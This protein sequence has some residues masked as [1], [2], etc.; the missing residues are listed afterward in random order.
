[1]SAKILN[2]LGIFLMTC[3]KNVGGI[4]KKKKPNR[5]L[6]K[7][8]LWEHCK[9]IIRERDENTCQRC[10]VSVSGYNA[11][12]SHVLPKGMYR[13]LEFDIINLKLLCYRCHRHFWHLNP[14]EAQEWFKTKFPKRWE[15]LMERKNEVKG[16]LTTYQ[17]EEWLSEFEKV[18]Q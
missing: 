13:W 5:K 1:M 4:L 9:R 2:I 10:G 14:L 8:K 17:L 16:S 7:K 18:K 3:A 12:T 6:L 15:Y 11:H